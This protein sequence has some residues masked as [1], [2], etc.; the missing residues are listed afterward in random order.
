MSHDIGTVPHGFELAY[1]QWFFGL[2]VQKDEVTL[3]VLPSTY[4]LIILDLDTY[5]IRFDS[6]RGVSML[7]I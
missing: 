3:N 7:L 1:P 2:V 6:H 5:F 4:R